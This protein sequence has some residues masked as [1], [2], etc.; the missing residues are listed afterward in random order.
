M[1][2]DWLTS[3]AAACGVSNAYDNPAQLGADRWA[4]LIGARALH[5]GACRG[6]GGR[7]RDHRR[8]ARRRAA[9]FAAA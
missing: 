8:R 6:G 5:A 2:A 1:S 9:A 3:S 4:A 7:H